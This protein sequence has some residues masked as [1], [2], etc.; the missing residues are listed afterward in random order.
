MGLGAGDLVYFSDLVEMPG[1]EYPAL[2]ADRSIRPLTSTEREG[3]RQS[4]RRR[5]SFAGEP[6]QIAVYDVLEFVY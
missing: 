3:Q 6:P 2:A 1:T 4:I 5:L